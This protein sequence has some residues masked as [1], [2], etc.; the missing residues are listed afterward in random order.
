MMAGPIALTFAET[1]HKQLANAVR[2]ERPDGN[3]GGH[4]EVELALDQCRHPRN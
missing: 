4:D 1:I 2:M 3:R